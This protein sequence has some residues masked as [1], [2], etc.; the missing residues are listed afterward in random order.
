MKKKDN[1]PIISDGIP[2]FV[3]NRPIMGDPLPGQ[4][5]HDSE[6]RGNQERATMT[7]VSSFNGRTGAVTLEPNDIPDLSGTYQPKLINGE[8]IKTLGNESLLGKGNIDLKTFNG[9]PIIGKGNIKIESE[10]VP[11][12]EIYKGVDI[13]GKTLCFAADTYPSINLLIDIKKKLDETVCGQIYSSTYNNNYHIFLSLSW[14]GEV[15]LYNNLDG[16]KYSYYSLSDPDLPEM[17]IA[18]INYGGAS[19]CPLIS[20]LSDRVDIRPREG[21]HNFITSGAVFTAVM[22]KLEEQGNFVP[23]RLNKFG[24]AVSSVEEQFVYIDDN[25]NDAKASVKEI[26]EAVIKSTNSATPNANSSA[27]IFLEI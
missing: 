17:Y 24:R 3:Y 1:R 22:N 10:L 21:S 13:K 8:N 5:Y 16:W 19:V 7:G 20:I 25:G 9:I 18:S 11:T 23:K 26:R 6:Q 15:E 14:V 12:K 4:E 27:Y 2:L